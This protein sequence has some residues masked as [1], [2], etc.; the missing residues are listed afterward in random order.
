MKMLL[1][2]CCGPCSLEPVRLLRER[3]FNLTI[4][5]ANANIVPRE[6]YDR[7][8]AELRTFAQ[9][10]NIEVI[11]GAYDTDAWE[12]QV[13]ALGDNLS[14]SHDLSSAIERA[15][16]VSELLDDNNRI[17]RCRACYRMR[18]QEAART[19][20]ENGFN[21][22]ATTLAISPY[23]FTDVI[24]EELQRA[25]DEAQLEAFFEDWRP[26]YDNAV[27]RSREMNMYRQGYCGCRFSIAEGAATR[28]FLKRQ[29]QL[30]KEAQRQERQIEA[31]E[32]TVAA[33]ARS[34]ARRAYQS[35]QERKHAI[36]KALRAQRDA[37]D[38]TASNRTAAENPPDNN[39]L[40][41]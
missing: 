21:T 33:S 3:G 4:M 1:H 30:R 9:S 27:R 35:K 32:S 19:A 25:A 41:A 40:P 8:L 18:L 11:E 23:Q 7:R 28:A 24:R 39:D 12:A 2:A 34:E 14:A 13:G 10:Q 22:L 31:Q 16:S 36:L 29:K 20:R 5:Y 15:Q 38:A 26:Y 37:Q 17:A 6:E